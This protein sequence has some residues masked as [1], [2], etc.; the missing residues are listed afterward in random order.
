MIAKKIFFILMCITKCA[1]A[2]LPES[3]DQMLKEAHEMFQKKE[4]EKAIPNYKEILA[5]DPTHHQAELNL[6]ISL[7]EL[8]KYAEAEQLFKKI[9]NQQKI[10]ITPYLYLGKIAQKCKK[11]AAALE[12]FNKAVTYDPTS[13]EA[14]YG[15]TE[16]LKENLRT[17]E[18]ISYLRT[19]VSH[20]PHDI[21]LEFTL[22][23]TLNMAGYAE[24]ALTIYLKLNKKHPNDAGIIY[25]IAYTLKKLG[26]MEECLPYYEKSLRI[27]PDHAEAL[28]SQGL[29]YL[30]LGDWERGWKGYEERWTRSEH[31]RMRTYS[32]PV[33]SGE[34]LHNKII[35]VYA[36]QGLGDTFQ[37]LR[38]LAILKER[39]AH[40]VFAPQRP[41]MKILTL[42]PYID[43]LSA[44]SEKPAHFDYHVPL[45][46]LPYILKTRIDSVPATIPYLYADASLVEEWRLKLA[47]DTNF[48][49]GICWQGNSEYTTAFLRAAVAGK[50]IPI[51]D[52]EPLTHIPGVTI[53][54]L[55]H[56][57]GTEQ[58]NVLPATMK[59]SLFDGDFDSTHG[60]FMDTAAVIKNLDLVITIDTS[61]CHFAAALGMPVWNLLPNPPDW[62]W[63]LNR[64][65]TPWYPNMKLFRQ[66]TPGDWHGT[67]Q[68]VVRELRGLV[69]HLQSTE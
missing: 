53:Y 63:M 64:T 49:V 18:A 58:L 7:F 48:K 50:S 19:A 51:Q 9:A 36:E 10:E 11:S 32:Q 13:K 44:F 40:I 25:N 22:A 17:H 33:W 66:A 52:F 4:Y 62:R 46:S 27:K 42:C 67:I 29:A 8:K 21:N 31:L 35:F 38:Y 5:F 30:V 57:T 45:V 47:H 65:D 20:H 23:N 55:Q 41:L 68:V 24:E 61:I 6:G 15:L 1:A 69:A 2:P 59:L 3:F 37:F 56:T 60:R 34:D 14:V 54:S 26:R 43:E 28:F 16:E 12:Y 39:G